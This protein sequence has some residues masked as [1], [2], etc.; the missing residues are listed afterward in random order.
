METHEYFS[1]ADLFSHPE[2]ASLEADSSG[3]PCVFR[4]SYSCPCG[5]SWE[6]DWSCGCDDE[7][8]A[9]GS[10]CSAESEWIGPEAPALQALWA[11]LPEQADLP[12]IARLALPRAVLGSEAA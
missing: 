12:R 9:C 6:N 4:N 11:Q 10:D 1:R 8:G 3:N 7:C 5:Q 2:F